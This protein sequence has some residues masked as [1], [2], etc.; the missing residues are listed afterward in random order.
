MLGEQI[1]DEVEILKGL[2]ETDTVVCAGQ[3]KLHPG[4]VVNEVPYQ[5]E[6]N[7]S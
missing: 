1:G 7:H 5:T 4:V 2:S 3:I 6:L